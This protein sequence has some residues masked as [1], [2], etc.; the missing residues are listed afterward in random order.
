VPNDYRVMIE[1]RNN[2]VPL[3][4]QAPRA[5]ITQSLNQLAAAL[6]GKT[7]QPAEASSKSRSWLGIWP[8]KSGA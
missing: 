1:V 3:V 6:S 2:G 7:E 8:A 5:T 4:Q